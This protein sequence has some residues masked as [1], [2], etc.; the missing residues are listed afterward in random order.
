MISANKNEFLSYYHRRIYNRTFSYYFAS[1][2]LQNSYYKNFISI[3]TDLSKHY[4]IS[5]DIHHFLLFFTS[6]IKNHKS[7]L[8]KNLDENT[9][10]LEE[11]E[12]INILT[13]VLQVL[14]LSENKRNQIDIK[15]Y[16]Q[17]KKD[18]ILKVKNNTIY[19]EIIEKYTTDLISKCG[20]Q[21]IDTPVMNSIYKKQALNN[22]LE[23][24]ETYFKKSFVAEDSILKLDKICDDQNGNVLDGIAKFNNMVKG[25]FDDNI[26]GIL[27]NKQHYLSFLMDDTIMVFEGKNIFIELYDAL[28]ESYKVELYFKCLSS[29][30]RRLD[31]AIKKEKDKNFKYK[32]VLYKKLLQNTNKNITYIPMLMMGNIFGLDKKEIKN[33]CD[34]YYQTFSKNK[35]TY[36]IKKEEFERNYKK[37]STILFNR[38][39]TDSY[40]YKFIDSNKNK[41]I[42]I[43]YENSESYKNIFYDFISYIQ[44]Y[45]IEKKIISLDE[46]LDIVNFNTLE[47][48]LI[49]NIDVNL[50]LNYTPHF[51]K[52][53]SKKAQNIY[54]KKFN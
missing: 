53:L 18:N 11:R 45:L 39:K 1:K 44:Y 47:L 19:Q 31:T 28:I 40:I 6:Y 54:L 33:L 16:C 25:I 27:K 14:V 4:G 38:D 23:A 48:D 29:A 17:N 37:F 2:H 52:I 49:G 7:L 24:V 13:D 34:N 8:H 12:F 32:Y 20:N 46:D 41:Q 9:K 15:K 42:K 43:E 5:L 3:Q 22:T 36:K 50:L 35:K 51:K 30:K 21:N 26:I 10:H